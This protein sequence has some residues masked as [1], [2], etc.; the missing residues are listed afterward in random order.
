MN[1]KIFDYFMDGVL[2]VKKDGYISYCNQKMADLMGGSLVRISKNTLLLDLLKT[3]DFEFGLHSF[4]VDEE[5]IF[6][7]VVEFSSKFG[8]SGTALMCLIPLESD[9]DLLGLVYLKDLSHEMQLEVKYK[10]EAAS[11]DQKILEM[12][13]LL[14]M[15]S[16][17]RFNKEPKI[18]FRE[19]ALNLMGHFGYPWCLVQD[20]K[21][22]RCHLVEEVRTLRGQLPAEIKVL[23]QSLISDGDGVELLNEGSKA[24]SLLKLIMPE[25]KNYFLLRLKAHDQPNTNFIFPLLS[26]DNLKNSEVE[27]YRALLDQLSI[28]LENAEL[29]ALSV[30][31]ELTNVFNVRYFNANIF[32]LLRMAKKEKSEFGV[33]LFDVD[34]FKQINDK[35]GHPGGDEVLR[36]IGSVLKEFCRSADLPARYGGEEFAI[37]LPKTTVENTFKVAERLRGRLASSAADFQNAKISFTASFGVSGFPRGG[38]TIAEIIGAADKALYLSKHQGRNKVNLAYPVFS[39]S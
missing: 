29:Q 37:L 5:Q 9:K 23:G 33:I 28:S 13:I 10:T 27:L 21:S 15:L 32:E 22:D 36:K 6:S 31:D 8:V 16:N 14:E 18:L 30:T 17:S 4:S 3:K 1:L 39:P 20:I 25:C 38:M 24:A 12:Q 7:R 34:H 19:F 11:K 2:A 26:G 35:Y